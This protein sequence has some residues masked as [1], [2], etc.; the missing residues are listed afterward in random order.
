MINYLKKS[1]SLLLSF[2]FFFSGISLVLADYQ[3]DFQPPDSN[4]SMGQKD[5]LIQ[6]LTV[7]NDFLLSEVEFTMIKNNNSFPVGIDS[8]T[9]YRYYSPDNIEEMFT[10]TSSPE[11][12]VSRDYDSIFPTWQYVYE[13]KYDLDVDSFYV[14]NGEQ[15][16]LVWYDDAG[17]IGGGGVTA[18][19][20]TTQDTEYTGG[21][22][23]RCATLWTDCSYGTD[24]VISFASIP[25]SSRSS[26]RAL[27]KGSSPGSITPAGSS[28]RSLFEPIRY[29][30]T[31]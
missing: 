27:T 4:L 2:I 25:I 10:T 16:L 11:T 19:Q 24:D 21:N 20:T 9:I 14:L 13:W 22:Y 28:R 26:R 7:T 18:L 15:Y 29:C 12:D 3:I 17:W 23:A 31:K 5:Y 30:L 6:G 1:V 8:F